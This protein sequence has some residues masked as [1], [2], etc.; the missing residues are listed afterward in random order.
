MIRAIEIGN[1]IIREGDSI[2]VDDSDGV[3]DIIKINEDSVVVKLPGNSEPMKLPMNLWDSGKI[4][5]IGES[6]NDPNIMF[7]RNRS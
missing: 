3:I 5:E 4:I 7:K 2:N 6:D 1:F